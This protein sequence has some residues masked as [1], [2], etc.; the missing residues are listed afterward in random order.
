M[1]VRDPAAKGRS[2][3]RCRGCRWNGEKFRLS[4]GCCVGFCFPVDHDRF[5]LL[6]GGVDDYHGEPLLRGAK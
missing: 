3:K 4:D 6:L 5:S 1:R 2:W